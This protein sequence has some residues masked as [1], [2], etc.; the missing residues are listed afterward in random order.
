M[1]TMALAMLT[2]P[3]ATCRSRGKRHWLNP[4][5]GAVS[6]A[7][8]GHPTPDAHN[9]G[10]GPS[11]SLATAAGSPDRGQPETQARGSGVG[12]P[13]QGRLPPATAFS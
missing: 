2:M 3:P 6:S 1:L 8:S 12:D 9:T 11:S 13:G 7:C 5:P 10:L 4:E